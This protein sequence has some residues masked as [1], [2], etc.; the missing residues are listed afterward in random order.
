MGPGSPTPNQPPT[1]LKLARERALSRLPE[2]LRSKTPKPAEAGPSRFSLP[3][4]VWA[5]FLAF[6][7]RVYKRARALLGRQTRARALSGLGLLFTAAAV[8]GPSRG[9]LVACLCGG[10]GLVEGRRRLRRSF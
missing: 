1:P 3:A 10:L 9:L 4:A 6:A 2:H 7:K 5:R 8:S